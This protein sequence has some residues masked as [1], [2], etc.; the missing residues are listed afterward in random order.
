MLKYIEKLTTQEKNCLYF[1]ERYYT[2]N[3]RNMLG[4]NILCIAYWGEDTYIQVNSRKTCKNG[5]EGKDR[6]I[7]SSVYPWKN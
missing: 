6:M 5:I 1:Q 7:W 2:L 3:S 4:E